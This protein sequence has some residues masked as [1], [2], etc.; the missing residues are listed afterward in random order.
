MRL[1][2]MGDFRIVIVSC[3]KAFESAL[4]VKGGKRNWPIKENDPASK[5]IQAAVEARSAAAMA[6]RRALGWRC[7]ETRGQTQ[8]LMTLSSAPPATTHGVPRKHRGYVGA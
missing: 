1:I 7:G 6:E 3:G 5:L 8:A 2:D 4:K